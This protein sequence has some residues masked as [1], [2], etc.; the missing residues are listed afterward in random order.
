LQCER[1]LTSIPASANP[2]GAFARSR[3][4]RG[5]YSLLSTT[6]RGRR[7]DRRGRTPRRPR[8]NSATNRSLPPYNSLL[9][10]L[11]R[12]NRG[13]G[14]EGLVSLSGRKKGPWMRLV[15]ETWQRLSPHRPDEAGRRHR[16]IV[17]PCL[18]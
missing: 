2:F 5:P 15:S 3:L 12:E 13:L 7:S 14:V 8:C 18:E 17:M 4:A 1:L 16:K 9:G 6:G 11:L 10:G